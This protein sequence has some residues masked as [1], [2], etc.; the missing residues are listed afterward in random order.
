MVTESLAHR[1][2]GMLRLT[3]LSGVVLC[4]LASLFSMIR[5]PGILTPLA[6]GIL[7]LVLF[8]L[9]IGAYL[10]TVIRLSHPATPDTMLALSWGVRWGLLI[11]A[12]WIIELL[13]G[14]L[15]DGHGWVL[16]PYYVGE[17]GAYGLTVAAGLLGARRTC[18]VS[19][20][21]L[22]GLWS[23]VV[24]GLVMAL[25]LLLVAYGLSGHLQ[26]DPQ[27]IQEFQRSGAPDLTTYIVG[28]F[29]AAMIGHLLLVG[30]LLGTALG[31]LGGL[32]G[33][34]FHQHHNRI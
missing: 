34:A 30:L 7:Y 21:A 28:D 31:A 19:T 26:H 1:N 14:N 11:A 5:Y 23:G 6:V 33:V 29:L 8:A 17:F 13:A 3:L 16:I 32:I 15:G 27:T 2:Y 20:G 9:T 4:L 18:R 22:I 25:A 24:S 12:L 10:V